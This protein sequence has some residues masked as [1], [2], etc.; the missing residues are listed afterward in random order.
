MMAREGKR[1]V[2]QIHI[3]DDE[4]CGDFALLGSKWAAGRESLG[5]VKG[6][7]SCIVVLAALCESVVE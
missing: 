5:T 1:H 3:I 4:R 2:A 6:A 7:S